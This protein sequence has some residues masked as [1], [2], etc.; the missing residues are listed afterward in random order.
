MSPGADRGTLEI[1]PLPH[2]DP[3]VRERAGFDLTH[4]YLEQCWTPILG[5]SGVLV[6]R[7][8]PGLW[9][10][11]S[12]AVADSDELARSVGLSAAPGRKATFHRALD[13]LATMGMAVWT[14]RGSSIGIYTQVPPVGA[15]RMA[16][17]PERTQ[18]AHRRHLEDRLAQLADGV[19][20]LRPSATRDRHRLDLY[21]TPPSRTGGVGRSSAPGREE[22]HR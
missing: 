10:E 14:E 8:L 13:R 6:L 18:R 3:R 7:A 17:R 15:G 4:P 1:T 21:A 22:R 2:P 16:K 12:P 19:I 5:P 9:A 11:G 20:P